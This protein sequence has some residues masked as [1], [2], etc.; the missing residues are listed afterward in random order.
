MLATSVWSARKLR[1]SLVLRPSAVASLAP[2][3]TPLPPKPLAS[4]TATGALTLTGN[5]SSTFVINGSTV[6]ATEFTYLDGKNAALVDLNDAVN[7]AITGTGAL[8]TGSIASGF[9]TI[10]TANNI[11]TSANISTTGT[12]TITSAGLLTASNGL[13]ISAGNITQSGVGAFTSGTGAISLNGDVAIAAG[14]NITFGATG[15]FDQSARSGT[16][17]TGTGAVS[18]NG[19]TTASSGLTLTNAGNLA[20]QKSA[21]YSTTGSTNNVNLGAGSLVRLTGASA[22]PS[23]VLVVGQMVVS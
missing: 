2:T 7:T 3:S 18:L 12:G 9:G 21:D 13:T 16:F 6:D 14:K 4:V 17:K 8:T 15:N 23:L 1:P 10:S 5:S 20:T 22:R 19:R 11:T